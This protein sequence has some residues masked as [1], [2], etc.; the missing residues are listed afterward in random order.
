MGFR[1]LLCYMFHI[2]VKIWTLWL[3]PCL[4]LEMV[5]DSL[6]CAFGLVWVRVESIWSGVELDMG[7]VFAVVL[8]DEAPLELNWDE[9]FSQCSSST[10][11]GG[12]ACRPLP[13]HAPCPGGGLLLPGTWHLLI[14]FGWEPY[15]IFVVLVQSQSK[16]LHVYGFGTLKGI[17]H[18]S[19]PSPQRRKSL[20][21][22][23]HDFP[24][25]SH[26]EFCYFCSIPYP[27]GYLPVPYEES[28]A[29]SHE[30]KTFSHRDMGRW[31]KHSLPFLTQQSFFSLN[32]VPPRQASAVSFPGLVFFLTTQWG[33]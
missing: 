26:G 33:L 24:S 11:A 14:G 29:F 8:L 13:L 16:R 9:C 6:H 1:F 21:W 18:W 25:L 17:S 31:V 19:C 30:P 32:P 15:L 23:Q 22:V 10:S 28:A 3:G 7:F 4:C 20:S 2:W 27:H 5:I 12:F